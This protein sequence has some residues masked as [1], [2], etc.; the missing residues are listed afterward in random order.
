MQINIA[1][2]VSATINR[3][4]SRP[5]AK[6]HEQVNA[7]DNHRRFSNKTSSAQLF[8]NFVYFLRVY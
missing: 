3:K 8:D 1:F 5:I 7:V 2:D 4:I 6:G